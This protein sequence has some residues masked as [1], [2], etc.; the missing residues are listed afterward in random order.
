MDTVYNWFKF[1]HV[2]AVIVWLGGLTG[3]TIINARLAREYEPSQL[4]PLNRASQFFGGVV[5][6]PA[7]AITLIAGLVM[8]ATARISFSTLW[9]AWGLG[10]LFLSLVL[11]ATLMRRVGVELGR[12]IAE[13]PE[14]Q[15]RIGSL[16]RRLRTLG[17]LNLLIVF[18][19][20]W[21]MVFKPTM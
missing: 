6:A 15:Q 10:G 17:L 4:I 2:S 14:D 1:L 3:I 11:G 12:V 7:G 20:V 16:Q 5:V 21:A 8:V 18:S 19:V 13:A 9:I